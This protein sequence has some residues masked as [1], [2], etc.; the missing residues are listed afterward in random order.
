MLIPVT[1][2]T[3]VDIQNADPLFTHRLGFRS[4]TGVS[5]LHAATRLYKTSVENAHDGDDDVENNKADN[6]LLELSHDDV[7]RLMTAFEGL[8]SRVRTRYDELMATQSS[9]SL[10]KTD[11]RELRALTPIVESHVRLTRINDELV[12]TKGLVNDASSDDELKQLASEELAILQGKVYT[13][14]IHF[15]DRLLQTNVSYLDSTTGAAN[16]GD[17]DAA[18]QQRQKKQQKEKE[19][20]DKNESNNNNSDEDDNA[21]D[22]L[23]SSAV[24]VEIRAGTGGD[25]A[26]L[27]AAELVDMYINYAKYN[28]WTYHIVSKSDTELKGTRET[29]LRLSSTLSDVNLLS[30]LSC[31]AGVHRVQ[32]V[33]RTESQGRIHTSTASVA[34]LPDVSGMK[35]S[36][37]CV[38]DLVKP[39]EIRVDSYRASGAG[40]QHVNTTD[41]AVRVT[42]LPT[43]LV[44]TCQDERSQHRNRAVAM[45][46]LASK[47]LAQRLQ[48]MADKQVSH[49]RAQL[50]AHNIG[51]RSDR[52]RTYNYQQRRVT[53]HRVN[54]DDMKSLVRICPSVTGVVT[55]NKSFPLQ[56]VLQGQVYLH[57]INKLVQQTHKLNKLAFLL[58]YLSTLTLSVIAF[59]F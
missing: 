55:Q 48:R 35:Q 1:D 15:I 37:L 38:E 26:A 2:G 20:G 44:A 29:I 45:Q 18:G 3:S 5:T 22:Y 39:N 52:I 10:S 33:P 41:S 13:L 19:K 59:F 11:R 46:T 58:S 30:E 28:N 14:S 43:G 49:R 36:V 23:S 42:H 50:G 24:L 32:R 56:M 8:I 12:E 53:D 25:E 7:S 4:L 47:L 51:E 57:R 27:F 16:S 9:S 54:V 17:D 31:E 6:I 34:I 40:G 21:E